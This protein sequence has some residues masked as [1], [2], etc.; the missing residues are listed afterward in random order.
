MIT[1]STNLIKNQTL[2]SIIVLRL[3]K[4]PDIL[5]IPYRL[6]E[7]FINLLM[8]SI[9]ACEKGDFIEVKTFHRLHQVTVEIT[10]TGH[11]VQPEYITKVFDPFFT[12]KE[13]GKGTGLGLSVCYNIIKQH[14]G[15]ISLESSEKGGAVVTI[16]LPVVENDE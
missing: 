5:G 9:D 1:S 6:E 4:I 7:V 8:N 12:T 10:D 16:I 15:D 13:V 14:R 2:S 3:S 11:G